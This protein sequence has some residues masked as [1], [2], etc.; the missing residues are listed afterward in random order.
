MSDEAAKTRITRRELLESVGKAAVASAVLGPVVEAAVGAAV[1]IAPP[2][3]AVAGPDRIAVLPGGTYLNGWAGYGEPPGR[4]RRRPG[5]PPPAAES[6]GPPPHVKWTK[7]SGPGTVT[8]ADPAAPV[9]T[10]TFSAPGAYVLRFA[11]DGGSATAASTLQVVVEAAGPAKRLEPVQTRNYAI[12]SPLW[13]DRAKALIVNWIPHCIDQINRTDLTQGPGGIDNFVEAAKALAGQPHGPHKGYVFSNAWV[14]QTVESMSLALMVDPRGDRDIVRA[15]ERMRATLEDW[16]P[17]ILAAQEPDGYLQTAFTLRDPARWAERWSP[18]ARGNHEG[19]VAGYFLESAINHYVMTRGKD[20]RLYDAAKKLAD[21]WEANLGPP[22]KKAWFDGHQEMEQALV[23]FG[24]FVNETEGGGK[25]D[26]YL[27]LAKFLLDS[28]KGGTEYDQSHLPVVQQYEAVGHAVRAVYTYSG[29]ADIVLETRDVDYQSAVRSLWDNIVNRKYYVTGGVG[30]GE[31]SEGFGPDY[32]LRNEAYC[33]TCSSCGEIFF[34]WKMNLA[35][36]DAKYADLYEET[37]Y[38]AL[39]GSLD[40]EGK[41]FYYDNP[42][43]ANVPRAP[44][45]VCPCCVGNLA[46]T[47]LMLPT[48]TY[49]RAADGIHVNLFIGGAVTVE[50]VAGTDVEIVQATD[51]P[52]NGRVSIVV[53]PKAPKAFSLRIRTPNR[54]V[55]ALYPAAPRVE[56]V[57]SIRV[58]GAVVKAPADKGYA[59]ITRL[60]KPGD[61]VELELPMPVQRVRASD[62]IAATRGRVALRYGPLVYNI[63]KADQDIGLALPAASPL[64]TEWK[65]DLLQGVMVIKGTFADGSPMTAIPNFARYNR[66]PIPEPTP[67]PPPA[68]PGARPPRPTPPPPTSIVWIKEA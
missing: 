5:Q 34:Q 54:Q 18:P 29:M 20:A 7:Q 21:C 22:P 61:R 32:S 1:P 19:Y 41:T 12:D 36:G 17:K 2:L 33:E 31:T 67:P 58:N 65:P 62:K 15:Q 16:I 11:A 14:H 47:L 35:Y 37:L 4:Q 59:V 53:N 56:G 3:A 46:R 40:L 23:R 27:R 55:S 6:P 13:K 51:Y 24:R 42:L 8:F 26:K 68:A 43:D 57:G 48:W 45:H 52:W 10:A 39:L 38:N 63:E 9:T 30:S 64:A 44:W 66:G 28:R 60:W 49:A 25:G 50:G